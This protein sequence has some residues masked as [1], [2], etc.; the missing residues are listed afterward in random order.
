MI[1]PPAA[2][3]RVI[4]ALQLHGLGSLLRSRRLGGSVI[5]WNSSKNF[6][7]LVH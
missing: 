3:R 6:P 2:M 7:N 1:P 5:G 4:G